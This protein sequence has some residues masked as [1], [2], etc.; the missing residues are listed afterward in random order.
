MSNVP[1]WLPGQAKGNR[2]QQNL[3]SPCAV[4]LWSLSSQK[5]YLFL[6]IS[7]SVHYKTILPLPPKRHCTAWRSCPAPMYA[8]TTKNLRRNPGLLLLVFLHCCG[9]NRGSRTLYSGAPQTAVIPSLAP[10]EDS[11]CLGINKRGLKREGAPRHSAAYANIKPLPEYMQLIRFIPFQK[12]CW[13]PTMSIDIVKW[14]V[15]RIS[16]QQ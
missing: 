9:L 2:A 5:P 7:I 11:I 13:N 8:T 12:G 10:V 1:G 4:S 16:M 14:K 6:K 3:R 15:G